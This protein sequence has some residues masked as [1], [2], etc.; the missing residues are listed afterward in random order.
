VLKEGYNYFLFRHRI[1][2]ASISELDVVFEKSDGKMI[3]RQLTESTS[4]KTDVIW[5]TDDEARGIV[6]IGLWAWVES[7]STYSWYWDYAMFAKLV[8]PKSRG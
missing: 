6:K 1:N 8:P 4:W 3:T 2:D 5:F 7:S